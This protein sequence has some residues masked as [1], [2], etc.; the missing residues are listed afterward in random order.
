MTPDSLDGQREIY[1]AMMPGHKRDET[2]IDRGVTVDESRKREHAIAMV[3]HARKC[4][5][6]KKFLEGVDTGKEPQVSR[7]GEKWKRFL[8]LSWAALWFIELRMLL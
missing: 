8:W 5:Q 7:F 3:A 1:K 2:L 4:K 6:E